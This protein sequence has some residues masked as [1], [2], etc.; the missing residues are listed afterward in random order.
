LQLGIALSLRMNLFPWIM[1]LALVPYLR[2]PAWLV[3]FSKK[4][5][6]LSGQRSRASKRDSHLFPRLSQA[7]LLHSLLAATDS[8]LGGRVIPGS[9]AR[10]Q[11]AL[12]IEQSWSMYSPN[13]YAF[14]FGLEVTARAQSGERL[15]L[16]PGRDS[17]PFSPLSHL[18]ADYRGGI[19]L[20][21]VASPE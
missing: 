16:D 4:L 17:H 6:P 2:A 3:A 12:G 1:T 21:N 5:E 18:W 8:V 7:F 20:E 11:T 9:I 15:L 13:P 19:Y 10:V 14:D